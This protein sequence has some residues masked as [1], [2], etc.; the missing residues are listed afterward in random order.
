MKINKEQLKKICANSGGVGC[1]I[2]VLTPEPSIMISSIT[3]DPEY[4]QYIEYLLNQ[5]RELTEKLS[6]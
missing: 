4:D 1:V 3:S 2:M 5:V 6:K